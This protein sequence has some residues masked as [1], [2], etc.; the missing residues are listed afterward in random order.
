[1]SDLNPERHFTDS[2]TMTDAHHLLRTYATTGSEDSFREIVNSYLG[3]VYSTALRHVGG[4]T[5]LA[6]DVSQTVF[7]DLATHAKSL[8][9]EVMLGGWLHQRAFNVARTLMRSE[10]RRT[11]R[12]KEAAEM[13]LLEEH[14]AANLARIRPALDEA[15]M[16]LGTDDR[17]AITLRFLEHRDLRSV[18]DALGINDDA[19]QKRVSRALDKMRIILGRNGVTASA[20][21]IGA[22]LAAQET[23]AMPIGLAA[24]ITTNVLSKTTGAAAKLTAKTFSMTSF[25]KAAVTAVLAVTVATAVHQ[26]LQATRSRSALLSLQQEQ[27]NQDDRMKQLASERDEAQRQLVALRDEKA[28]SNNKDAELLR[29][30][31]EVTRLKR[32]EANSESQT[33]PAA[34]GAMMRLPVISKDSLVNVHKVV[35][36]DEVLVTAGWKQTSS[37]NRL[38]IFAAPKPGDASDSLT[39]ETHI[40]EL[41]EDQ[42]GRYGLQDIHPRAST[43]SGTATTLT[44]SQFESLLKT[45]NDDASVRFLG[46]PSITTLS[47]KEIQV[48]NSVIKQT[49][50]GDKF[51]AGQ[52]IQILP[53]ISADRRSV[54]LRIIAHPDDLLPL[55]DVN[56]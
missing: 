38:F 5:H 24:G 45:A 50:A 19:A 2:D 25:S 43:E 3:L 42:V 31:G 30:R 23:T 12:E 41:P 10:R 17:L 1:L 28:K 36:W 7:W 15:I 53:T 26:T 16:R 39:I 8:S 33:Q 49:P 54:E 52:I 18:G 20:C 14:T 6:E 27:T 55:V 29:L 40:L 44:R 37:T 46:S 32:K 47:G 9:V 11:V 34:S 21:A 35:S 51:D 4:D 22:A 56:H 48:R 13:S